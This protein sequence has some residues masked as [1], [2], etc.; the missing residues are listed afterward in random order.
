MDSYS[1]TDESKVTSGRESLLNPHRW[2]GNV[3]L[4]KCDW[5]WSSVSDHS[6]SSQRTT[7]HRSWFRYD[8]RLIWCAVHLTYINLPFKC[9][10]TFCEGVDRF[11]W[12]F[13]SL[14]E[15]VSGKERFTRIPSISRNLIF[16]ELR[17]IVEWKS[18]PWLIALLV[19]IIVS[20]NNN[21]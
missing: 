7:I 4:L 16:P 15:A 9:L 10:F 6:L 5:Q 11:K 2:K 18:K 3:R 12:I 8:D 21:C 19:W 1:R 13:S 20:E 14:I 17:S